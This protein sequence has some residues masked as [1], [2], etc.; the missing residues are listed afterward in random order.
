[1][2]KIQPRNLPAKRLERLVVGN[3]VT[4]RIEDGVANCFPGLEYDHRNLDRR[5][6]PGLVFS[7]VD[8]NSDEAVT[9]NRLGIRLVDVD[10]GDPALSPADDDANVPD[11]ERK[12][13]APLASL[14]STNRTRL[15]SGEWYVAAIT[16]RGTTIA[17]IDPT[18]ADPT[19]LSGGT[20]WRIV[21]MLAA[22][23]VTLV[24]EQ[25]PPVA[26]ANS[27]APPAVAKPESVTLPG[28]R[29]RF[30]DT[31]TGL[32]SA[33]YAPGELGQSLC[34]PWMHD[35]RDCACNYWAS[36][37]PDIVAPAVPLGER[38]LGGE[39]IG[40]ELLANVRVDWLRS[41]RFASGTVQGAI[42][43]GREAQIDHYEINA[44]WQDLDFVLGGR[45]SSGFFRPNAAADVKPFDTP[46]DLAKHL[47]YAASLE[48]VLALEYLYARYS[49]K[50]PAELTSAPPGLLDFAEYARHEL[51]AIA[52]GEMRHL[53]WANELLW[54]LQKSKLL[55]DGVALPALGVAMD[56]P[57]GDV[58]KGTPASAPA[59]LRNL[60]PSS[61]GAF[62]KGERPS[63]ALDGLYSRVVATLRKPGTSYPP[64]ML[65][66]TEQIV[67]DG[68]NHFLTFEQL[69][70]LG[71]PYAN[72]A[73]PPAY[74][75]NLVTAERTDGRVAPALAAYAAIV[76]DL[77]AGYRNGDV[78]DR[79][80]IPAA[81]DKMNELDAL[82]DELG[83]Q[84]IG[85][86][87][88]VYRKAP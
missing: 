78:E 51:L 7:F 42:D 21:R 30:I 15:Q 13:A 46:L 17:L 57:F 25:R 81:R 32:L 39:D 88:F 9:A 61:L 24:L 84:G 54:T 69:E 16:Q 52:V 2:N 26:A 76:A 70:A 6:F 3:P 38:T 43:G 62:V 5:F 64:G 18:A 66:L 37:H 63:G 55:P 56:I 35:F 22:D 27:A 75:R 53:R 67:A 41:D 65:E 71:A 4:T 49:V 28:W 79:Q 47:V 33:A 19:F 73:A 48:H 72:A 68:V 34:S 58:P 50:A 59:A 60:D 45:E 1:M 23:E 44:R 29:R 77:H 36:N 12:L 86:P 85:I 20:A 82:A 87:F 10:T 80:F 11:H 74:S 14:L 8:G 31:A 40:N 83:A